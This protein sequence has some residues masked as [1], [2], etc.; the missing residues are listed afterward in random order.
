MNLNPVRCM[1]IARSL[2]ISDT[3]YSLKRLLVYCG[4]FVFEENMCIIL[5]FGA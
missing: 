5:D 1:V 3:A 2:V 4:M